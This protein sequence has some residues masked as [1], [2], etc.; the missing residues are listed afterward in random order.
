M[1]FEYFESARKRKK[2]LIA[3]N[4]FADWHIVLDEN[5]DENKKKQYLVDLAGIPEP[6]AFN[7]LEKI[8]SKHLGSFCFMWRK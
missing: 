8:S 7:I 2:N 5:I 1:Q 3:E 4:L 6:E